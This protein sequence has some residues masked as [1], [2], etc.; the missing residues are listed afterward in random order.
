M[1]RELKIVRVFDAPKDLV[2]KAWSDPETFM[3]WWGP[4]YFT[5]PVCKMDFREGGKYHWCMQDPGGNRYWTV[6]EYKEI[7]PMDKIVYTD[8]F[9]DENGNEISAEVYGLPSNFPNGTI[10]TV[11][12]ESQGNKTKMTLIH[13]GLP[14]A[15]IDGNTSA[16]WNQS[17]DKLAEAIA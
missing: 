8:S 3:K 11:I 6:G 4:L 13:E 17:L 15:E 12:F 5:S 7:K 1:S 16:G 10:V 14:E 2:W 9:A